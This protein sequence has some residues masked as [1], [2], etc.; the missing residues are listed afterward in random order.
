MNHTQHK[1]LTTAIV[2]VIMVIGVFFAAQLRE[3]SLGV[4]NIGLLL[5]NAILL[6]IILGIL[7]QV[8]E[9]FAD[10]NKKKS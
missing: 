3:I 5:V 7:L 9:T 4:L 2:F 6:L 1:L 8:K 10:K